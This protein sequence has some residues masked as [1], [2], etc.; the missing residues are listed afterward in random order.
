MNTRV[1]LS[2]FI[3]P[4]E[5]AAL[6]SVRRLLD[7]VQATLIPAHVTL[8]REAELAVVDL[9]ALRSRFAAAAAMH[10]TLRFGPPE[11][12]EG[13]GILLPCVAGEAQF[14]ELR[15]WVLGSR[16]VAPHAPHLTLAHPRNPKAPSNSLSNA[17]RLTQPLTIT[18]D[19]V[20]RIEQVDSAP[21]RV[22]EQ[23]SLASGANHP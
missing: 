7:P 20:Q 5:S 22:L 2:M 18:F 10:L 23:W 17:S 13:H 4:S 19:T 8:C 12:F 9:A 14:N 21:W 16:A 11:S 15:R 1:Q 3:P 6:E